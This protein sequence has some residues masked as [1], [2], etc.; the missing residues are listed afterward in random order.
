LNKYLNSSA[1]VDH[2][3]KEVHFFVRIALKTEV[4]DAKVRTI[5]DI[6]TLSGR[7]RLDDIRHEK[8]H[9]YFRSHQSQTDAAK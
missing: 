6:G 8:C 2:F 5:V 7:C 3:I 9:A 1:P 4:Y